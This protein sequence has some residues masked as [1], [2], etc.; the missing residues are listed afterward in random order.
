MIRFKLMWFIL[1]TIKLKNSD[2]NIGL[3]PLVLDI[4]Q[5][6]FLMFPLNCPLCVFLFNPYLTSLFSK[7]NHS[8]GLCIYRVFVRGVA[9]KL[10]Y[11]FDRLETFSN[12][13]WRNWHLVQKRPNQIINKKVTEFCK[14]C[15]K[16]AIKL[17]KKIIFCTTP[18]YDSSLFILFVQ[19][20]HFEC[21]VHGA[22]IK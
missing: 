11:T 19:N 10:L 6:L 9:Y 4:K 3:T 22:G 18:M 20:S 8:R 21:N 17:K 5:F 13:F 2:F 14:S 16:V 1:Y 12:K 7:T 15:F